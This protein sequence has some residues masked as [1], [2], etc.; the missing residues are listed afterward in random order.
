MT[1]NNHSSWVRISSLI[2]VLRQRSGSGAGMDEIAGLLADELA[3]VFDNVSCTVFLVDDNGT[4]NLA[5]TGTGGAVHRE[6]YS[7]NMPLMKHL[8]SSGTGVASGEGNEAL[9]ERILFP[10]DPT[11]SLICVPVLAVEGIQGF[12]YLASSRK[13]AFS[14]E[15]LALVELAA[16]AISM[17][18][19]IGSLSSLVD[20]LTVR[21]PLTGCFNRKKFSED[22]EI[23]IPC[24]E[25][26]GKPLSL[27]KI[28]IDYM[29]N[30]NDANGRLRG[31]AVI[32][33]VGE[34]LSYSIRMC[35]KL[36]RFGGEEFLITLPGIDRERAVFAANRLQKVLGQLSFE[37]EDNSQPAGKVTYS[38]G[39]ASFPSDA[40]Y[41][42]G[43][44]RAVDTALRKAKENGGNIVVPFSA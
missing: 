43:L 5:R 4:N 23:D 6:N 16:G 24:S 28:D 41:R 1:I 26:Y 31:D 38:I 36:Y 30:F 9:P 39:V 34:T 25:R 12:V 7:P 32:A 27:L 15:D 29:K 33:K 13:Q 35:D 22:I 19:R 17:V 3:G 2:A 11:E 21:D 40:V 8:A 42:D 37:G 20:Q 44:I 10:E 18:T 14:P